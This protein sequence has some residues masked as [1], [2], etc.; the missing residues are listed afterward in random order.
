[1]SQDR[2][3]KLFESKRKEW[4]ALGQQDRWVAIHTNE[5]NGELE[6]TFWSTLEDAVQAADL[7]FGDEFVYI[8][9]VKI[10][11]ITPVFHN[12]N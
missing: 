4:L 3:E 12:L 1:M 8:R 9:Q 2:E 10:V 5:S 11:D 7:R 6:V